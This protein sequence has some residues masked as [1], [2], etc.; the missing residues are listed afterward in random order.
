[1]LKVRSFAKGID[2]GPAAAG[3]A[4]AAPAASAAKAAPTKK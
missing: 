1:M 2:A 4:S 3:S